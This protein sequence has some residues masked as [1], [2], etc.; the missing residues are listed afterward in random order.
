MTNEPYDR[1]LERRG[2][3]GPVDRSGTSHGAT[4]ATIVLANYGCSD[5]TDL[6]A[7]A[8]GGLWLDP[9]TGLALLP[10]TQD[11]NM[12]IMV[13]STAAGGPGTGWTDIVPVLG[14]SNHVITAGPYPGDRLMTASSTPMTAARSRSPAAPRPALINSGST[15]GPAATRTPA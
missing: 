3:S 6:H 4:I 7:T 11:V 5:L 15:P 2:R 1:S 13:N 10:I 12:E 9:G 14:L 8:G